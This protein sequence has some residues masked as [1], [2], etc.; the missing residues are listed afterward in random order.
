MRLGLH[1][2]PV[3][4]SYHTNRAGE[5][6][7]K[8]GRLIHCLCTF[9]LSGAVAIDR[10][11]KQRIAG[12]GTATATEATREHKQYATQ[13]PTTF[14]PELLLYFRFSVVTSKRAC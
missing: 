8:K 9:L 11:A 2:L 4:L 5:I 3:M 7:F 1:A 6:T 14:S 12:A 13:G 10:G